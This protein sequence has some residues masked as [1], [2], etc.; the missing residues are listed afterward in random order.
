VAPPLTRASSALAREVPF[1]PKPGA[2]FLGD[3]GVLGAFA[4]F[5]GPRAENGML[6]LVQDVDF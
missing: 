2:A 5:A 3:W 1:C 4:H 6:C